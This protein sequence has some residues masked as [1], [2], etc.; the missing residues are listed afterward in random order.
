MK[1]GTRKMWVYI[2]SIVAIISLVFIALFNSVTFT[3]DNIER[4]CWMVV[5]LAITITGG[6]AVEWLAKAFNKGQ[7]IDQVK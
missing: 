4:L 1:S 3:G 7:P 5:I 2:I 6:N